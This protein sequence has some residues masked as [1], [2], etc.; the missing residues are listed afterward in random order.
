MSKNFDET[1]SLQSVKRQEWIPEVRKER[2]QGIAEGTSSASLSGQLISRVVPWEKR[3]SKD[4]LY[5]DR[6]GGERRQ[7]LPQLPKRLR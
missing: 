6:T 5:P 7:F 4:L 3:V 1:V 2:L